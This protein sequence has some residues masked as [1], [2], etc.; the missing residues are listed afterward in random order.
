M[1]V[2]HG[3][4]ILTTTFLTYDQLEG[5]AALASRTGLNRTALVRAGV[6]AVLARPKLTPDEPKAEASVRRFYAFSSLLTPDQKK[7]LATRAARTGQR[8]MALVRAGVDL[9]LENPALI[10]EGAL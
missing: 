4:Y 6:N 8:Q 9:V 5:L 7:A 3:K 1:P 10:A 2:R